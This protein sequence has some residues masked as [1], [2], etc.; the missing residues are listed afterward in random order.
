[1]LDV[2]DI[3]HTGF[4]VPDLA[5]AMTQLSAVFGVTWTDVEDREM[6]VLGP[7]GPRVV[8]L[9]FV[10]SQGGAPRL[11]LLE[12]VPGTV[13]QEPGGLSAAHHVGVW[14]DDFAA[15]SRKLVAQ[16]FP[17]VMTFD[18]GS[19]EAVRFA[20]HR[21]PSGPLVE[22]VDATRRESLEAWFAGAAYP[23]AR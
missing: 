23:A 7:D 21:L 19:G 18:D 20:Y 12:P 13:W 6:P 3:F 11:E 4:V 14:C 10:Y 17:R 16:G 15:T 5:A 2:E 9:R 8:T 1:M 22:L